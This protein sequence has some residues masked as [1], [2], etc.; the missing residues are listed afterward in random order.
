[1]SH[2]VTIKTE[3]QDVDALRAACRRLDLADPMHRTVRLFSATAT[4][5]A[6]ELPGWT[7]PVVCDL[8]TGQ[9]QFDNFGEAW[10]QQSELNKLLQIYAVEK[11]KLEARR[12]GH[13]ACEQLLVDGSIR[14]TIQVAG[15][16]A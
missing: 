11:A 16:A 13:V 6:V 3:I 14:L 7:Y 9:I 4:G 5:M 12:K 8:A 1:M 15:G 2:V 10:G